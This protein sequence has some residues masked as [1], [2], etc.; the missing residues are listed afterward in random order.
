MAMKTSR[1]P[2]AIALGTAFVAC[3]FTGAAMADG[4]PFQVEELKSPAGYDQLAEGNC[5]EGSCGGDDDKDGEGACGEGSC[6][7]G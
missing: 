3:S 1:K 5:G 2:L 7:N 4:N 6:G